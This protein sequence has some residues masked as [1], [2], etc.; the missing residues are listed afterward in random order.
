MGVVYGAE[1]VKRILLR[2]DG[3]REFWECITLACTLTRSTLGALTLSSV[4]S[5]SRSFGTRSS[6]KFSLPLGEV[7]VVS[8]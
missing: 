5:R 2:W 6:P 7:S 1:C 8:L 4:R 3:L